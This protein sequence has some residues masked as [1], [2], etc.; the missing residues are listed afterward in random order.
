MDFS[1]DV[2]TIN[3]PSI[4]SKEAEAMRPMLGSAFYN[5]IIDAVFLRIVDD[6]RAKQF[7]ETM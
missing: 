7:P 2:L 4:W 5:A 3:L 1:P 6:R